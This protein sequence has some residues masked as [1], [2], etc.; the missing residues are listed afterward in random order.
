[1]I[2]KVIAAVDGNGGIGKRG[3]LPWPHMS[4]DMENFTFLT[5][6]NGANAVIMGRKTWESLHR[7]L[8]DRINIVVSSTMD[9]CQQC[10]VVRTYKEGCELARGLNVDELWVIGGSS[11]YQAALDSYDVQT[12]HLTNFYHVDHGCDC[13]FPMASLYRTHDKFDDP[14]PIESGEYVYTMDVY[15]PKTL[16]VRRT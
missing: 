3:G 5:K 11:I 10:H 9:L 15:E 4:K 2:T 12:V 14:I 7:P 6:G 1:M 8:A 13:F 16:I